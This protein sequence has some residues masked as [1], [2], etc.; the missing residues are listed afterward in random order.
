MTLEKSNDLHFETEG[1]HI[2]FLFSSI[3]ARY[4]WLGWGDDP[5]LEALEGCSKNSRASLKA[6]TRAV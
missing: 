5:Y 4:S 2:I 6:L 3:C 1:V